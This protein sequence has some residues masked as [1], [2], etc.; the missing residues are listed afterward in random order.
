MAKK[1]AIPRMRAADLYGSDY[2]LMWD[3]P[4][5]HDWHIMEWRD[6]QL[7]LM[8]TLIESRRARNPHVWEWAVPCG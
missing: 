2:S 6:H 3:A 4:A 7:K 5:D 1:K 8:Q